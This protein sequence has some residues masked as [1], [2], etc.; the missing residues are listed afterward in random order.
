MA[1]ANT[2]TLLP[3]D[4]FA[5]IIGI[6][7]YEVWTEIW[8]PIEGFEGLYDI[9]S[10]GRVRSLSRPYSRGI[11]ILKPCIDSTGYYVVNIYNHNHIRTHISIH[12]LVAE[13]FISKPDDIK[14]YEVNHKGLNNN[15]LLNMLFNLEW[16]TKGG[17]LSHAHLMPS[18]R[19]PNRFG[20]NNPS[21]KLKLF[22]VEEIIT[23]PLKLTGVAL[24]HK[25]SVSPSTISDIKLRRSWNG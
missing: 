22:E 18:R 15:K 11:Q 14:Y 23:N 21:V 17:N 6:H 8:K 13:A 2:Y 7:P 1:R 24:S 20:L 16:V 9:S 12:I 5:Q 19:K 3:L 25:F 4:R 10:F